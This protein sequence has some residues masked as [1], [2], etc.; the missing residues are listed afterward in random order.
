MKTLLIILAVIFLALIIVSMSVAIFYAIKMHKEH[1]EFKEEFDQERKETKDRIA[2]YRQRPK[3]IPLPTSSRSSN[4]SGPIYPD[5]MIT[6]AAFIASSDTGSSSSYSGGYSG[7]S[8]S[9]DSSS[10]CSSSS[11]SSSYD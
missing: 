4:S 10:S 1:K 2:E 8:G 6:M 9:S 3:Q 7:C 11:S 5:P